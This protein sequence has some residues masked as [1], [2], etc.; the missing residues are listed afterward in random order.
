MSRGI[1]ISGRE[2]RPVVQ[3]CKSW[4]EDIVGGTTVASVR[5]SDR[6]VMSTSRSTAV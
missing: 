5:E 4:E 1:S 6:T 2:D 3:S